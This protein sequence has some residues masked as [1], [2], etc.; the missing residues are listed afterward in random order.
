[1]P[2]KAVICYAVDLFMLVAGLACAV[3]GFVLM[4]GGEGGYRGSRN[5]SLALGTER[6]VWTTVHEV[7]G[8]AVVVG[9]L[10][11]LLLHWRWLVRMSSVLFKGKGPAAPACPSQPEKPS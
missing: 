9:V 2:K 11:H 1:M 5:A 3:S 10:V 7:T 4:V 8:M 6:A